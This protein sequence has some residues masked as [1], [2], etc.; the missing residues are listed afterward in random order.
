[1]AQDVTIGEQTFVLPEIGRERIAD[2]LRAFVMAAFPGKKVRVTVAR[3]TRRRSD[4]QN[5]YLWGVCYPALREATGQDV[6]DWHEYMLGEWAGW[7]EF[8]MFG[9]K[10]LRP[11]RRSS[12][13]ST[14]E[15]ADYV[16]FVQLRA[17]EHGIFIPDPDARM[18]A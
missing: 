8:E 12:K 2:N 6:D 4:D 15:F 5:R 17:A 14:V 1:M 10:R 18:A 11:R 7:E 3:A 13:L 9:R 16:A